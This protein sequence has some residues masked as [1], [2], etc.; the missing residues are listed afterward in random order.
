MIATSINNNFL[1]SQLDS[2]APK[3]KR[4]SL[5]YKPSQFFPTQSITQ[6]IVNA[7]VKEQQQQT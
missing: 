7:W 1:C 6:I 5:T 2:L 3:I 4:T